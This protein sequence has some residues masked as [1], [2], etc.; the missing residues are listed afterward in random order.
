MANLICSSCLKVEFLNRPTKEKCWCHCDN[1]T[2]Y[3]ECNVIEEDLKYK[4][5]YCIGEKQMRERNGIKF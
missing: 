5:L 3:M 1:C 2:T 4:D